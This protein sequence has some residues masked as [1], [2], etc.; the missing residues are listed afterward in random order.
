MPRKPREFG[1]GALT[2]L[3]AH[4]VD[5]QPIFRAALDQL[6]LLHLL[7][8]I[9]ERIDWQIVT[10]CFMTTHYH[11]LVA[12]GHEDRVPWAMQTVNSVYAREF[13]ARHRRRGH[14]FGESYTDTHVR[15]EKHLDGTIAYILEN[16][17][18]AGLVKRV[19]EWP[20]SGDGT[21]EPRFIPPGSG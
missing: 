14:L 3:T 4:G 19:E 6:E 13:N 7:K 2:H 8:K 1:P 18:R 15:T 5:D 21:L 17:I 20:W 11:L 12:V 16:P 9:A 10:W